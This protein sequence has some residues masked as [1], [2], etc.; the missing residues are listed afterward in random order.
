MNLKILIGDIAIYINTDKYVYCHF[1]N[2]LFFLISLEI[3]VKGKFVVVITDTNTWL[4]L[5][6]MCLLLSILFLRRNKKKI[7]FVHRK[8]KNSH[9]D[10]NRSL[11]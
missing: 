2:F 7:P 8:G 11:I 4:P 5:I 9:D 3:R 1:F 6:E 10:Y